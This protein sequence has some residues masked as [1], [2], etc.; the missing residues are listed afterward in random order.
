MPVIGGVFIENTTSI[1][2]GGRPLHLWFDNPDLRPIGFLE[3]I[4]VLAPEIK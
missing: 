4:T 1:R 3:D 2:L